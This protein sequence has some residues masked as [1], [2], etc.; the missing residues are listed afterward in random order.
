MSYPRID[1][2]IGHRRRTIQRLG[3]F[4]ALKETAINENSRLVR[5]DDVTGSGH[6]AASCTNQGDFHFDDELVILGLL[7]QARSLDLRL[8]NWCPQLMCSPRR[9]ASIRSGNWLSDFAATGLRRALC[10]RRRFR[11]RA[12]S[13]QSTRASHPVLRRD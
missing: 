4:A 5:L 3:F 7:K 10:V 1:H 13:L 9:D 2:E 6:F 12:A 11:F 8:T